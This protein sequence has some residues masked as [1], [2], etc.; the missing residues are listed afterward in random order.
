MALYIDNLLITAVTIIIIKELKKALYREFKIKNLGEIEVIIS[1]Y[2]RRNREA[3]I[4]LISQLAYINK[5]LE[6]KKILKYHLALISI[7]VSEY[8]FFF[9][10]NQERRADINKY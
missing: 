10:E 3:R 7:K 1:I 8:G 2:I 6:K 4:L 5:L 9:Y